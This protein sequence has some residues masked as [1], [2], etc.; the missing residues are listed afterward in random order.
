MAN[1]INWGC[2]RVP[3]FDDAMWLAARK[4]DTLTRSDNH[5]A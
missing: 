2:R 5:S 1:S 3:M 4:Q